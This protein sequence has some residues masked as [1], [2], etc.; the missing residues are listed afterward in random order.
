MIFIGEKIRYP[1]QSDKFFIENGQQDELAVLDKSFQEFGNY[2][3]S[4]QT[5]VI[6]LINLALSD[7][8]LKDYLIYPAIFLIRHYIELRL[9]ELIQSL[10][11]C[12]KTEK[13]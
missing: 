2:A 12:I 1:K 8:K 6:S 5:G 7:I 13:L 4:Y 3:D 11:Y 9:K 10:N